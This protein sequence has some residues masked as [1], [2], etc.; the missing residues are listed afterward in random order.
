[1]TRLRMDVSLINGKKRKKPEFLKISIAYYA[2]KRFDLA[3]YY[4]YICI[5]NTIIKL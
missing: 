4:I 3:I 1:M 5:E 2:D